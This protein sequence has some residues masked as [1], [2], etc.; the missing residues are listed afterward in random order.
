MIALPFAAL[1]L[2][3]TVPPPFVPLLVSLLILRA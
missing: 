1:G 2:L 3:A